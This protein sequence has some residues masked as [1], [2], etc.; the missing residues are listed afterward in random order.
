VLSCGAVEPD[1]TIGVVLRWDHRITDA[2]PI[3]RLDPAGTGAER[4]NRRRIAIRPPARTDAAPG[5]REMTA[6]LIDKTGKLLLK[7][8]C[9]RAVSAREAFRDPWSIS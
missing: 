7:A 1:H 4:R 8:A 5:R 2:A 3:A 9:S 6:E